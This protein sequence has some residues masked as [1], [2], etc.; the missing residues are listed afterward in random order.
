MAV[1]QKIR[2]K[3]G[4]AI[5]IIIALALLSFIIDPGTLQSAVQTMSSKYDVGKINGKSIPYTDF[6]DEVEK[7]SNINEMLTGT[8]AQNEETQAS[9]RDAAWQNLVDKYLFLKSAKDAG[10]VVGEQEMIDLT[11]GDNP[12]T[13]ITSLFVD[14]NGNFDPQNVVEFVR[15]IPDDQT[16]RYQALWDYVQ[17]TVYTQQFYNKYAA[18]FN[19]SDIQSPLMLRRAIEENNTTAT[20]DF[21]MVPFG[22]DNDTTIVV[23]ADEIKEY[24]NNHKKFYQQDA[25]RD[26]EYI[27]YEVIPSEADINAALE[28][29]NELYEEFSTTDNMRNF[30]TRNSDRALSTYWYKPGELATISTQIDQFAFDN[31]SVAG[32]VSPVIREGDVFYVAKVMESE[33]RADSVYVKHILLQDENAEATADS[34]VQV[35]KK[36]GASFSD[37]AAQYSVDQ[38]SYDNG[39]FGAI[40]WMTQNYMIQGMESVLDAK[41]NEPYVL[42]SIYGTHVVMVTDKSRPMLMKQVAIFEKDAVASKETFNDFYAKANKFANIAAGGYDNFR[43]AVDSMGVYSHPLSNVKE[44]NAV[45]GSIDN[46]KEVTRWIFDAKKNAVSNIITVNNNYF[47]VVALKDIHKEGIAPVQEVASDIRDVLYLDK[48]AVKMADETAKDIQGCDS[49]EAVAEKLNASISTVT[50]VSFSALNSQ[51]LDPKF[52]GAIAAAPENKICGPVAGTIGVYV[53]QVT[54]RDTGAF[55]TEDDANNLK[56]QMNQYN[57][58]MIIPVMEEATNTKDNRARFF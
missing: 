45:Y 15:S 58:Q 27:V 22:F 1:L 18:L 11:T 48:L 23:S 32:T 55:Y 4:L 56:S 35:L 52:L 31:A 47:F 41:V 24:Y 37:L 26:I 36:K 38:G 57:A 3:F 50:D 53:F 28:S 5:S 40:G 54:G 14:A 12:S 51:T 30:L 44:G 10:L 17:N 34:L 19:N 49:M 16:G 33:A 2:V 25:S 6:V 43:A 21:V 46:A 42:N 8:T 13:V 9:I 7:F 20:V 39:E 29:V